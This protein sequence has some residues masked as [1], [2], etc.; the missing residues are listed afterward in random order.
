[1]TKTE[2]V[3]IVRKEYKLTMEEFGNRIGVGRSAISKIE[4][5]ERGITDQMSKSICREF[6]VNETWFLTG[7]GEML[8]TETK[9]QK[10]AQIV[11]RLATVDEPVKL[12]LISLL[13]RADE[14]QLRTV[15][16]QMYEELKKNGF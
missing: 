15:I 4:A 2:R 14:S 9:Q 8:G 12:S 16:L 5:G 13:S 11:S 7:E 10:I 3:K 1:M 6:H